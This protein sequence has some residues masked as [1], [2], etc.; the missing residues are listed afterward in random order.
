MAEGEGTWRWWA[1]LSSALRL[2]VSLS[3]EGRRNIANLQVKVK[4]WIFL[5]EIHEWIGKNIVYM[6]PLFQFWNFLYVLLLGHFS[7]LRLGFLSNLTEQR[8]HFM[9]EFCEFL[10]FLWLNLLEVSNDDDKN[11]LNIR[12]ICLYKYLEINMMKNFKIS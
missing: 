8:K 3:R 5:F 4:D 9:M 12:I 6:F 7:F 1:L 11:I 10:I 2:N